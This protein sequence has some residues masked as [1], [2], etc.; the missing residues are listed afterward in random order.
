MKS[1]K[2]FY[3]HEIKSLTQHNH[4]QFRQWRILKQFPSQCN[5]RQNRNIRLVKTMTNM[6]KIVVAL[7][8]TSSILTPEVKYGTNS[9]PP[10]ALKNPLTIPAKNPISMFF[11]KFLSFIFIGFAKKIFLCKKIMIAHFLFYVKFQNLEFKAF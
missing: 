2:I 8:L 5:F 9:K 11:Q 7:A 3:W 10:P 1:A 6:Q 4:Q